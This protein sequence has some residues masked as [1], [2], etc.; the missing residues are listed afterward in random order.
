[1]LGPLL[2]ALPIAA[3]PLGAGYKDE[4]RKNQQNFHFLYFKYR[5]DSTSSFYS[6]RP[7]LPE[8]IRYPQRLFILKISS[9]KSILIGLLLL[10]YKASNCVV[11]AFSEYFDSILLIVHTAN[12]N[13]NLW[14][15]A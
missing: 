5:R 11:T 4:S 9:I 12:Q 1:L 15:N 13:D 14:L 2:L 10:L 7:F 8:F 6:K 3:G